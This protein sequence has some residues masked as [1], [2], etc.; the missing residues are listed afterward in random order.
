MLPRPYDIKFT[1][2]FHGVDE[3]VPREGYVWGQRVLYDI[4][5]EFLG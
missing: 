3:R 2:M 1:D 5:T 4:V